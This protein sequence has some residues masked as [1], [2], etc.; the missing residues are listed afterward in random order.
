[1]RI[2][3]QMDYQKPKLEDSGLPYYRYTSKSTTTM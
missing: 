2:D 3:W 1:L